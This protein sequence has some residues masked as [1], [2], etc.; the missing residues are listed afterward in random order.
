[1]FWDDVIDNIICYLTVYSLLIVTVSYIFA[2]R[3]GE[4]LLIF[5]VG[6]CSPCSGGA[7]WKEGRMH[8]LWEQLSM[9]SWEKFLEFP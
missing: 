6:P 3:Q 1:M 4:T 8:F 5:F 2:Q 7:F 9:L